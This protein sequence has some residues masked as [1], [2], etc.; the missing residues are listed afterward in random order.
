ML[1]KMKEYISMLSPN[2]NNKALHFLRH[3]QFKNLS[4][5]IDYYTS[6]SIKIEL[7]YEDLIFSGFTSNNLNENIVAIYWEFNETISK[8]I[9][10]NSNLSVIFLNNI[11]NQKEIKT[12]SNFKCYNLLQPWMHL[13]MMFDDRNIGMYSFAVSP[14]DLNDYSGVFCVKPNTE[15]ILDLTLRPTH[16]ISKSNIEYPNSEPI[17]TTQKINIII[18]YQKTD[19]YKKLVKEFLDNLSNF[20]HIFNNFEYSQDKFNKSHFQKIDTNLLIYISKFLF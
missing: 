7:S 4:I 8:E 13:E 18:Q 12:S 14:E 2:I 15:L 6:N 5:P 9:D 1:I 3:S 11:S 16:T 17:Q 20:F 19:N 10:D